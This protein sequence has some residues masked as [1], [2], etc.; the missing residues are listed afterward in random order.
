MSKDNK[1]T[2]FGF[3]E[4]PWEEKQKKSSWSFSLSSC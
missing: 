3:S 2:D 4:V 1:T